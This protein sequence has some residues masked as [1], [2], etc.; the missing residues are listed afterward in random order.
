[1]IDVFLNSRFQKYIYAIFPMAVIIAVIII[2][3]C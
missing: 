1:M 2:P 3:I